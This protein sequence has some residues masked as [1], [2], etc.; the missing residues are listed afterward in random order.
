VA[1]DYDAMQTAIKAAVAEGTGL[2]TA[3]VLW[4][5]EKYQGGSRPRNERFVTIT[6][7][8]SV[9]LGI[10][11]YDT[12]IDSSRALGQEVELRTSS[13]QRFGLLIQCFGGTPMGNGSAMQALQ[14]FRNRLALPSVRDHVYSAYVSPFD[15][16]TVQYVPGIEGTKF[17][18]RA[19]LDMR[20]YV[21]ASE[22]EYTGF[23]NRVIGE[24][25]IYIGTFIVLEGTFDEQGV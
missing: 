9:S 16:G 14:R 3:N 8:P 22:V 4:A 18:G 21:E 6:L 17:E 7:G 12:S 23:I 20:C 25:D 2:P 15:A 24:Y 13:V 11:S 19:T 5:Y 1:L 10:D